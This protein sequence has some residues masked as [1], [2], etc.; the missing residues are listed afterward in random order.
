MPPFPGR[1]VF[2]TAGASRIERGKSVHGGIAGGTAPAYATAHLHL[3][4]R[5]A[6]ADCETKAQICAVRT[7]EAAELSPAPSPGPP[8]PR[9]PQ[10]QSDAREAMHA[11]RALLS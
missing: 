7:E 2:T 9:L 6:V 8:P 5:A 3:A 1:F 4:N 11:M 10:M